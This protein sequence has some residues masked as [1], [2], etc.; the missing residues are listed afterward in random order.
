MKPCMP[1][2][3]REDLFTAVY[4]INRLDRSPYGFVP[5]T[6]PQSVFLAIVYVPICLCSGGYIH[7]YFL[8]SSKCRARSKA[9]FKLYWR[10]DPPPGE[11]MSSNARQSASQAVPSRMQLTLHATRRTSHGASRLVVAM[12]AWSVKIRRAPSRHCSDAR[13][14]GIRLR[15]CTTMSTPRGGTNT[16]FAISRW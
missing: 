4:F 9:V 10:S 6:R 7:T 5:W 11:T 8:M 13:V 1:G 14:Y 2:G 15:P 16:E 12:S 3:W